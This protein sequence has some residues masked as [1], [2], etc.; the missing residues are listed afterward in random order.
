MEGLS[1]FLAAVASGR[2]S[3]PKRRSDTASRLGD[4]LGGMIAPLQA[5]QKKTAQIEEEWFG[6]VPSHIAGHCRI[7][8]VEKG[9]LDVAVD[10]PVYAYELR[11]CSR[12]LLRQMRQRCP[13]L[14]LKTIKVNV[15]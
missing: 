11:M 4:V 1:G 5:A 2:R 7:Q 9:Q 6:I 14:G 3:L 8:K 10:S 13:R 12:D 15:A